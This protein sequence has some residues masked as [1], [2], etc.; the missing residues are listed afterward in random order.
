MDQLSLGLAFRVLMASLPESSASSVSTAQ[1]FVQAPLGC[2]HLT[3]HGEA[4][5]CRQGPAA[6]PLSSGGGRPGPALFCYHEV[7]GPCDLCSLP[8]KVT[9]HRN[10]K[11][12]LSVDCP[13]A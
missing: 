8:S 7:R 4:A 9:R 10:V 3:Q 11:F 1:D 6:E 5:G 13:C 12:T 2:R